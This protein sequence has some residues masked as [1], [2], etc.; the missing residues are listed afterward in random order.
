[1]N[2]LL[3]TFALLFGMSLKKRLQLLTSFYRINQHSER[4]I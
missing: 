3:L 1:M 2:T 4:W